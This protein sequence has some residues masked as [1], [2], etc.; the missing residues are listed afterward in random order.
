MQLDWV[1]GP[2]VS[3]NSPPEPP[4]CNY[5][6]VVRPGLSQMKHAS[7]ADDQRDLGEHERAGA[8]HPCSGVRSFRSCRLMGRDAERK[9]LRNSLRGQR[10]TRKDHER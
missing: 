9:V 1:V 4:R 8:T 10:A 3:W 7:C 6:D 5:T 2:E